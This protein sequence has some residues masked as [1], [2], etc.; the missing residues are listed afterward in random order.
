MSLVLRAS[1]ILS[2]LRGL[3]PR[4]HHVSTCHVTDR[5]TLSIEPWWSDLSFMS[6]TAKLIK[7]T[8]AV[9]SNQVNWIPHCSLLS[10]NAS[11]SPLILIQHTH[12]CCECHTEARARTRRLEIGL[13]KH[14]EHFCVLSFIKGEYRQM[15]KYP[16]TD[17]NSFLNFKKF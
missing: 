13:Y 7:Q 2:S 8:C 14:R 1:N 11:F 16:L 12:Y 3:P 5:F 15:N 9:S 10:G 6:Y 4:L 17:K